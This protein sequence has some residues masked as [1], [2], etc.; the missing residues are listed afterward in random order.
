MQGKKR[1]MSRSDQMLGQCLDTG[2][3]LVRHSSRLYI[4]NTN[5][6]QRKKLQNSNDELREKVSN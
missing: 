5:V 1:L 6:C 3:S 4:Y 2:Y